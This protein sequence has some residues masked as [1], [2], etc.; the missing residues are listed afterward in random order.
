MAKGHIRTVGEGTSQVTF[1]RSHT[2]RGPRI[3]Q[4]PVRRSSTSTPKH[5]K[6]KKSTA[7][8]LQSELEMPT[9]Q[10]SFHGDYPTF[11]ADADPSP[12]KV[13][14]MLHGISHTLI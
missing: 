11:M 12:S 8:P 1:V 5:K 4:V 14:F 10:E 6:A 3:R 2:A 13:T 9:P 7:T